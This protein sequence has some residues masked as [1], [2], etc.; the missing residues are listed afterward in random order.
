MVEP[1]IRAR[2]ITKVFD[3]PG[4]PMR[5]FWREVS[6]GA[7]GPAWHTALE[8]VDLDVFPGET[9]GV[10]GRNGAGKSTLLAILAGIQ[11]PTN[12]TVERRGRIVPILELGGS[13]DDNRT[14]H[15]NVIDFARAFGVGRNELQR[16]LTETQTFAEVGEAFNRP[17][18]TLSSGTRARVAFAA[19]MALRG[20]LVILDETL[21][22]GDLSFRIK[23]YD[24]IRK[25]HQQGTAFLL[26][27]HNQNTLANLCT[28]MIVINGARVVFDGHPT[29][30]VGA[31]KAMRL[32][33]AG[34]QHDA[35]Q[36][37]GMQV[38]GASEVDMAEMERVAVRI[39]ITAYRTI[40]DARLN[41]GLLRDDGVAIAALAT[42]A[43]DL[44]T[45][46]AGKDYDV[47]VRFTNWIA[48]GVYS[49]T[50]YVSEGRG[51]DAVPVSYS[52]RLARL[53]S[54]GRD[55]GDAMADVRH[56]ARIERKTKPSPA[57]GASQGSRET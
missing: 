27:S 35:L 10:L 57:A 42:T 41:V 48:R 25:L 45:F 29:G 15:E 52:P 9:V 50:G 24:T 39:R 28:R 5:R 17:M 46:E 26:V 4:H 7:A 33:K 44:G 32:A 13:F 34:D 22:V 1:L 19:A 18:R 23:C 20:D 43:D 47:D 37:A 53:T 40:S 56:A 6:G 51:D 12:G 55:A 49:L 54:H 38:I 14:G 8:R 30:A 31:Y 36:G 11:T 3:R 16:V 2:N 21:A